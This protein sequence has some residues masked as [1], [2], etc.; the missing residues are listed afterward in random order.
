MKQNLQIKTILVTSENAV[1]SQIY[2]AMIAF[3]LLEL[4]RRVYCKSKTAV[5][6]FCAKVRICLIHYLSFEYICSIN[7]KVQKVVKPPIL[8]S[9]H[10]DNF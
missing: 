2:I 8:T 9:F 6:N 1:K 5:S 4:I 10:Q 3:L 7:W